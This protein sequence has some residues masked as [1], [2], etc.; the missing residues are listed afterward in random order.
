M[1]SVSACRCAPID[2]VTGL[3][4]SSSS[5]KDLCTECQALTN[6]QRMFAATS[7][8]FRLSATATK[9]W[10]GSALTIPNLSECQLRLG[11]LPS[12]LGLRCAIGRRCCGPD[13]FLPNDPEAASQCQAEDSASTGEPEHDVRL[14][15]ERILILTKGQHQSRKRNGGPKRARDPPM[16]Q[17]LVAQDNA[18]RMQGCTRQSKA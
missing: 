12:G 15:R 13:R 4:G 8:G 16:T 18:E 14:F 1:K 5:A 9:V 11:K 2:Q 10:N 7:P 3:N 17:R 6:E